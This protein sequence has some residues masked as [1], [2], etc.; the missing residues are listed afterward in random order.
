MSA[1][2]DGVECAGA[3]IHSAAGCRI[4]FICTYFSH[5]QTTNEAKNIV[6][7]NGSGDD[8][9]DEV[10]VT[11]SHAFNVP[12]TVVRA[13]ISRG[14]G[15][16]GI[17]T[18]ATASPPPLPTRLANSPCRRTAKPA[19]AVRKGVLCNST[20][21]NRTNYSQNLW[22]HTNEEDATARATRSEKV[23]TQAVPSGWPRSA[24]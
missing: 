17:A 18:G 5:S 3:M 21:C 1:K 7:G 8:D 19:R 2:A 15:N 24:S 16:G 11:F 4:N 9:D 10:F 23:T 13:R 14:H 22:S 20:H 12:L 6:S